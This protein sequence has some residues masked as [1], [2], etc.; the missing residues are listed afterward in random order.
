V[1]I[2]A[3]V[4]LARDLINTPAEDM[5]PEQLVAAGE[6]MAK[7]AGASVRV[8]RGEALLRENYPSIHTVGRA[9]SRPPALLDIRWGDPA[10][11]KVTL[12]GKGVCFDTGGLNLKPRE[13]MHEM[14][15]DMGGGAV[16]LGL[17]HA[18]MA[19]TLRS[20]SV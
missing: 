17:A 10:A 11:L 7:A 6:S 14:K 9:S 13:G 3:G 18:L 5:G 15:K 1:R 16:A 19:Q 2:A 8:I 12:V 4:A 20:G